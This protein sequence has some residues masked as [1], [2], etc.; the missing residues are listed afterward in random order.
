MHLEAEVIL[1]TILDNFVGEMHKGVFAY[2]EL[3][4]YLKP[5]DL[6]ESPHP[7]LV[8]LG[9]FHMAHLQKFLVGAFPPTVGQR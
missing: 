1:P 3:S 4:T 5:A 7:W 6:A 8:P 9:L 2:E